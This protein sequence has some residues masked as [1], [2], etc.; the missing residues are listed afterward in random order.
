[1]EIDYQSIIDRFSP[2]LQRLINDV[3]RPWKGLPLFF[4]DS[5]SY[6]NLYGRP[7]DEGG[8]ACAFRHNNHL[9]IAL[10]KIDN[11]L[12]QES[13]VAHELGHLWLEAKKF[14]RQ[15]GFGS[16]EQEQLYHGCFGPLLEI[17]EHSI[18]FPWLRKSYGINLY[19]DG[20]DRLA[21]FLSD[22]LLTLRADAET[23]IIKLTLY[24]FKYRTEAD[25]AR[26]QDQLDTV[27]STKMPPDVMDRIRKALPIILSLSGKKPNKGEF[28][29]EYRQVLT[30]LSIRP[31]IWPAF[32]R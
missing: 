32:I 20:N 11:L 21:R 8:A 17:M 10:P 16:E 2:T 22:E 7:M 23:E 3:V 28:V 19:K 15:G 18:I 9:I 6:A 30:T 4:W 25:D 29:K 24:F 14:P 26:L 12:Q 27:Y 31:E 5:Q 1:M 13:G